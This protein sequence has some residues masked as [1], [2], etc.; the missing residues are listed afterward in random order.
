MANKSGTGGQRDYIVITEAVDS[1][2]FP[3]IDRTLYTVETPW[4]SQFLPPKNNFLWDEL[5]NPHSTFHQI[6]PRTFFCDIKR[7]MKSQLWKYFTC[8]ADSCMTTAK[9]PQGTTGSQQNLWKECRKLHKIFR[10]EFFCEIRRQNISQINS[11]KIELWSEILNV[12][13]GV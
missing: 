10:L 13:M 2:Q 12:P 7:I 5:W 6:S 8:F 11:P 1:E 9:P 4:I 3:G